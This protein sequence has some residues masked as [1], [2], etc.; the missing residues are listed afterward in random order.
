MQDAP[1]HTHKSRRKRAHP[2]LKSAAWAGGLLAVA[3]FGGFLGVQAWL[4]SYLKSEAFRSRVASSLGHHL[5]SNVTLAPLKRDGTTVFT[6]AV[7]ALGESGAPF[8]Q[9]QIRSARAELD[10]NALWRRAWRIED[11]QIQQL[12]LELPSN[13]GSSS[14]P[15]APHPALP[16]A[17]TWL[18]K[19]LPNHAE[20]G[21]VRV[22]RASLRKGPLELRQARLTAK[23]AA[24]DW[25]VLAET[26][27]I[28]L[29][30]LPPLELSSARVTL[31]PKALV[32]RNSRALFRSG[33]EISSTGEWSQSGGT[34]LDAKF[35]NVGLEPFLNSQWQSRLKGA[36]QGEV[37]FQ[38]N[39]QT[40]SEPE[41]SGQI[42]LKGGRLESLPLLSQID[43]FLGTPRFRQVP[44]KTAS[45]RIRITPQRFEFHELQLDGDGLMRVEGSLFVEKGQL[46]GQL[47]LGLSPALTQWLPGA[48]SKVFTEQRDGYVWTP[49]R[50]TGTTEKPEED[51]TARLLASAK[52]AVVDTLKNSIP[53]SLSAPLPGAAKSLLDSVK[54]VLPNP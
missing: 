9:C 8:A 46:Q 42:R 43:S 10:L 13:P 48:R 47:Q 53:P 2:L 49:V 28:R 4:E 36:L 16:V 33:G 32:I 7:D 1:H 51:L 17:G 27:E 35:E 52:D 29:P 39:A 40:G 18:S 54:S 38:Q 25:E 45:A 44:L 21:V 24:S 30:A 37:H 19:Y 20:F 5:R 12:D 14:E 26:G 15:S 41:L 50:V 34:S 23:P 11:L 6:D 3:G 31:R 22:A